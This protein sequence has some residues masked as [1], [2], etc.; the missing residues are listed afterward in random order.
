MSGNSDGTTLLA[1]HI[2]WKVPVLQKWELNSL[3]LFRGVEMQ[4]S[5]PHL[6]MQIENSTTGKCKIGAHSWN[7]KINLLKNRGWVSALFNWDFTI[8]RNWP[9]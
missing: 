1:F 5:H 2:Q 3:Q 7:Q 6:G 4:S 9:K 8:P